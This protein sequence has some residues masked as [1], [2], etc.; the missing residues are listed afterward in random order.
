VSGGTR[1]TC[2]LES[3]ASVAAR[4][5]RWLLFLVR[6]YCWRWGWRGLRVPA[7]CPISRPSPLAALL[8]CSC[9]DGPPPSLPRPPLLLHNAGG[10]Q[11]EGAGPP[12]FQVLVEPDPLGLA[13]V[14]G[15]PA[16]A[17]FN[18]TGL[19]FMFKVRPTWGLQSCEPAA[20]GR[21][22]HG[23]LLLWGAAALLGRGVRWCRPASFPTFDAFRCLASCCR[24]FS[25]PQDQYI[26][27]NTWVRPTAHLYGAGERSSATTYITV[28]AGGLAGQWWH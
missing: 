10:G 4:R 14:R 25:V 6:S 26:E 19:R 20:G 11:T 28:R 8:A 13:V 2:R 21:A 7:R 18:T 24:L 22:A 27:L 15:D 23:N 5:E 3:L 17:T 12:L 1:G 16:V 9:S